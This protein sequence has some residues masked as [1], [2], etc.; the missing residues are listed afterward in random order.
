MIREAADVVADQVSPDVVRA[1]A[2]PNPHDTKS[3][4]AYLY[5]HDRLSD[6]DWEHIKEHCDDEVLEFIS[7]GV[8]RRRANAR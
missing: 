3:Q 1:L 8:I 6:I 7:K 2:D 5:R 4:L